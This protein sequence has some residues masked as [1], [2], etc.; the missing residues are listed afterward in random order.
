MQSVALKFEFKVTLNCATGDVLV[1]PTVVAAASSPDDHVTVA[2]GDHPF[3]E[4]WFSRPADPCQEPRAQSTASYRM[5]PTLLRLGRSIP[6]HPV[7]A[8]R[9]LT[10]TSTPPP[11]VQRCVEDV[12]RV[13]GHDVEPLI[14]ALTED[15]M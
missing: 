11:T 13:V 9:S 1:V 6:P 2:A 3:P 4:F 14:I 8:P 7:H 15:A 12:S 10:P 5:A